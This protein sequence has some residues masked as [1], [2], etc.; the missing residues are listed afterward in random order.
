LVAAR[1][2]AGDGVSAN[3]IFEFLEASFGAFQQMQ[4]VGK[5][6]WSRS[7]LLR[8]LVDL[9][10][11]RLVD[12]SQDGRYFLTALG[13]LSGESATE[14]ESI[15]RLIDCLTPLRSEEI[16]DPALITAVQ[17]TCE[18]DQV[19]FPINKRSKQKEPQTWSSELRRQGVSAHLLNILRQTA[20]EPQ[21]DT[22]RAKKAVACLLFISGRAMNE[23]EARMTQ[24]GGA[25]DGAAGPIRAVS[26]RACDLL[27]V[28][29]R[30]AEILH[31]DLDLAARVNRLVVRLT[32]GVHAAAVDLARHAGADLL[33]G[34]YLR[35]SAAG[36]C[37][38]SAIAGASDDLLLGCLDSDTRKLAI[39][40][41]AA[42]AI[43]EQ[44][45]RDA[46][47][48]APILDPYEA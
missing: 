3:N 2:I 18:V 7:D 47:L 15:I 43:A 33:R 8:A 27:P 26:G 20:T 25:S 34:D 46:T 23:I 32:V 48:V 11:H 13:R 14:V 1:R 44:R 24:F 17:T 38:P 42:E 41:R 37:E 22:L 35:L 40:R 29:A 6:S 30:V 19:L 36:M 12:V 4:R 10:R 16:S 5:W 9:K 45:A 39:V 31:P 28:A 21:Q